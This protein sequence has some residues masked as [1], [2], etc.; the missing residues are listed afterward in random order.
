MTASSALHISL[1]DVASLARVQRAVVSMWR[2]RFR[3]KERPFPAPVTQT[4]G[5]ELFDAHEVAAWLVETGHGNNPQ[6]QD[7]LAAFAVLAGGRRE[8]P[9]AFQALTSLLTLLAMS[10][11]PFPHWDSEDLLDLA[12]EHDPDDELLYRELEAV[13][14]D[15]PVLAR[16]AS[17]LADAAFNPA[18][19][20]ELLMANRFRAGL[21]SHTDTA[22]TDEAARLVAGIAVELAAG[23]PEPVFADPS[24]GG[25]DLLLAL[26]AALG[27]AAD[28]TLVTRSGGGE[29]ARLVRRRLRVHGISGRTLT[30]DPSGEFGIDG[31]AVHLAHYPSPGRPGMTPLEILT[32]V[33]Q[34]VLQ[35]DDRQRGVVL[36]PAAVLSDVLPKG[37]AREVRAGLIRDGRVRAIVRLPEGLLRSKPRQ[38]LALWVLGPAH[39][40]VPIADRWTVVAD[41]SGEKLNPATAKD[42]ISDV[43]ASLGSQEH[44]R[45][46]SFR[47]ARPVLT[48]VILP[49]S[50][51]LTAAAHAAPPVSGP[52][53]AAAAL[54]A[55]E[56]LEG[57]STGSPQ[58]HLYRYSVE[59]TPDG[60]TRR[61]P[62]PLGRLMEEGIVTY[63]PGT[64]L[65]DG[66]VSAAGSVPVYGTPEL[67]GTQPKGT[68]RMELLDFYAHVVDRRTEPGDVVFCTGPQAAAFVDA[69]GGAVV[70]YPARVLRVNKTKRSGVLPELVAADINAQADT[71]GSWRRWPVRQ[72]PADPGPEVSSLL[73]E[74]DTQRAQARARLKQ[75]DELT[76]LVLDGVAGGTVTVTAT[77][78]PME[79]IT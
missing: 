23:L 71:P 65:A 28:A 69:A 54:R 75:L 43:A 74:L 10:G 40:D 11:E 4:G 13:Q 62:R 60:G 73:L 30:V 15:L 55:D 33:D 66:L 32:A 18:A 59:P 52:R 12:D 27:D 16:F 79:G 7:D 5:Q 77:H 57:L 56:L 42:L 45:A 47:F 50:T 70:Q 51:A 9:L 68:R 58:D 61:R 17:E 22:L 39:P 76:T 78:A 29:T 1:S 72:I 24:D 14:A 34:A 26:A 37:D 31:A 41:L 46:H 53:G 35:M 25:S 6:A 36:A 20:F 44:V 67:L 2:T 38:A 3:S 64:R 8:D 49:G 48:R 63:V 19:A 21:R